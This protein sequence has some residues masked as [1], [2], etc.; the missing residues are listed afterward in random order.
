MAKMTFPQEYFKTLL[1]LNMHKSAIKKSNI[2]SLALKFGNDYILQQALSCGGIVYH[3][4]YKIAIKEENFY[5]FVIL[6]SYHVPD[7]LDLISQY[8]MQFPNKDIIEYS[9][10]NNIIDKKRSLIALTSNTPLRFKQIIYYFFEY[11]NNELTEIICMNGG[12]LVPLVCTN[13]KNHYLI[14]RAYVNNPNNFS[15]LNMHELFQT[16]EAVLELKTLTMFTM[17]TAYNSHFKILMYACKKFA[18]R[19]HVYQLCK[20][21]S[22]KKYAI[23]KN[24][25]NLPEV[26]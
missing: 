17:Y 10:K 3:S 5:K 22:T 4:S 16:K 24:I 9:L 14:R 23:M 1:S 12:Q 6:A 20:Y 2:V 19:I 7:N 15:T 13:K 11:N 25:Y 21:L 8:V 18:L 26:L